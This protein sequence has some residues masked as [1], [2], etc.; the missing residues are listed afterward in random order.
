MHASSAN[1]LR[2]ALTSHEIWLLILYKGLIFI[3]NQ[4]PSIILWAFWSASCRGKA[5]VEMTVMHAGLTNPIKVARQIALESQHPMPLHRVRPMWVSFP[6]PVDLN[7]LNN[8][9][10]AHTSA[11]VMRPSGIML[12]RLELLLSSF[13]NAFETDIKR[14]F[15][16]KFTYLHKWRIKNAFLMTERAWTKDSEKHP[17]SCIC[18]ISGHHRTSIVYDLEPFEG[19]EETYQGFTKHTVGTKSTGVADEAV[20]LTDF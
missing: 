10:G 18:R 14:V 19:A 12:A 9:K 6:A 15:Q 16:W 2:F 3:L 8:V 5:T 17:C 13:F 20:L 7:E 4:K 11:L 1:I